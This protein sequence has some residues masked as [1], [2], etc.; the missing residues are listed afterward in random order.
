MCMGIFG[1]SVYHYVEIINGL[2][3]VLDH[4]VCLG[5]FMHKPDIGWDL[6]D[7]AAER[8]NCFFKLLHS[9]V[10]QTQVIENV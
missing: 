5:P 10:G 3:M 4:L 2:L 6:F 7:T 1:V 8:E 9:T